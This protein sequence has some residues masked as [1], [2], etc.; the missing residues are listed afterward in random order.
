MKIEATI[1]LTCKEVLDAVTEA[2]KKEYRY[3]SSLPDGEALDVQQ[4]NFGFEVKWG[5]DL[6]PQ[7]ATPPATEVEAKPTTTDL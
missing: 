6:T 3:K 1:H 7:P 2:I 5:E 4:H